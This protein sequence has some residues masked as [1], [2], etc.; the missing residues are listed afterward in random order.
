MSRVRL[1]I[2]AKVMLLQG[3]EACAL[4]DLSQTGAQLV[5]AG[6]RPR[7]GAGAVL[8]V[9]GISAFGTVIWVLA[10][11]IGLQFDEVLPLDQVVAIRHFADAYAGHEAAM[12]A[13]NARDFVQGRPRLRPLR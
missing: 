9:C 6:T 4:E 10:N 5:L 3:L 7:P 12:S 11:R 2:P 1:G 13:R 8:K